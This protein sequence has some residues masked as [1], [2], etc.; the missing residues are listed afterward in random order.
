MKKFLQERN[1]E[2]LKAMQSDDS[3]EADDDE[4]PSKEKKAGAAARR[5][6][7][8]M[9]IKTE[10]LSKLFNSNMQGETVH[11]RPL[12]MAFPALVKKLKKD[13]FTERTGSVDFPQQSQQFDN[14]AEKF[15]LT[16]AA[17]LMMS[18]HT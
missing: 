1:D 13:H 11:A 12:K 18:K 7:S 2:Y 3:Q 9:Q 17:N 8:P 15:D 5:K 14:E 10:Y 4:S 16:G 6:K